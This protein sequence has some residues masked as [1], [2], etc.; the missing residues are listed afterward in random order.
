MT[1]LNR[2]QRRRAERLRR[3]LKIRAIRGR[4]RARI[5]DENGGRGWG[6]L[7]VW[8]HRVTGLPIDWC[9]ALV[10]QETDFRH[11]YG[12]DPVRNPIKS[13]PG[14]PRPV[15][16]RNYLAYKLARRAGLGMQG[17]GLTQP[18]WFEFQDEADRMGGCWKPTVNVRWG[19]AHLKQLIA[20]HGQEKGCQL[21]NGTG[22]RAVEYARELR[23]KRDIWRGRF[24]A[25]GV[26]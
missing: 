23:D 19:F 11:I 21:Y 15:T 12:Q 13:H 8:G 22:P 24:K 26:L 9:A 1:Q 7:I 10:Q 18:T 6:H 20:E 5:I 25:A 14:Q 4:A 17:V 16:R 3:K 2:A